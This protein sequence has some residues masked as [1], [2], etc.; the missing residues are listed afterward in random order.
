M[1]TIIKCKVKVE[2]L[3]FPKGRLPDSGEW[4]AFVGSVQEIYEGEPVY[5]SGKRISVSGTVPD[6]DFTKH[7]ILFA[8][9]VDHETYGRQYEILNMSQEVNLEDPLEQRIFLEHVLSDSQINLLYESLENPFDAIVN[10]DIEKLTSVKGIGEETARRIIQ[11]YQSNINNGLAYVELDSYGLTKHMLD[12]LIDHYQSPDT[13]V[14]KI[15]ENPYI[16]IEEVS[17][18][19]WGKADE[20]ARNAGSSEES[21]ERISAFIVHHLKELAE[22]GDTWTTP[23]ELIET[24]FEILDIDNQDA[25]RKA[26]YSLH[27]KGMLW[28]DEGKTKIALKRLY[29]LEA[30]IANELHRLLSSSNQFDYSNFDMKMRSIEQA[31]GSGFAFTEEQRDAVKLV[32]ENQV[33]V[34]TGPGGTGKSTIVSGVLKMLG[35]CSFAQTALSGR[36]ASRLSEITN[37]PGYT[38]HRLLAYDPQSGSFGHDKNNPLPHDVIILDEVS[39][40]GAELFH[41]LIQAIKPGSK[42]IMIGDDGQLESIGLCNIFKDMLDSDVIPVARLTKIHRQAAKSAI[43]T[44]SIKV[45]N[46]EQLIPSRWV[47]EEVRGELRDL[48]LNIFDDSILGGGLILLIQASQPADYMASKW[49][50]NTFCPPPDFKPAKNHSEVQGNL[51]KMWGRDED[52][53]GSPHACQRRN[54]HA[55]LN[56][57]IQEIVNPLGGNPTTINVKVKRGESYSY[58]LREGDK[59]IVTK[60]NYKTKTLQG[61]VCPV[62]NGNQGIIESINALGGEMVVNFE[63]HGKVILKRK[64]WNAVELGYALTAHKLQGSEADYVIVGFDNSARI[65][66]T[67]EWLYTAITRAKKYCVIC[68]ETKALSFAVTNSNVPFKKTLLNEMLVKEE[69]K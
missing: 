55:C 45:R 35:E 23:S 68:A 8:K 18:I 58:I 66:L 32:L 62:F 39:M 54:I 65:M 31:H 51:R 42:L 1:S 60:N 9:A 6:I 41:D 25:F 27:D 21:L 29:E 63:Q 22:E 17:G 20:M 3:H 4:A 26:L 57:L 64:E 2:H 11:R 44:E 15:K 37:A 61:E 19:G 69:S 49:H 30:N 47:G 50:F 40:V 10:M 33:S 16:L 7:Y 36:A 34:I 52:P 24:A 48:E 13:L 38:I 12:K 59:V 67:K 14:K 46:H 28:W 5:K 56:T 43:I 53:S